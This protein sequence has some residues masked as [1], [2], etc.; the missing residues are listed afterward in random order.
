LKDQKDLN[1]LMKAL[2][3]LESELKRLATQFEKE[4][5]KKVTILGQE[6]PQMIDEDWENFREEKSKKKQY[7][8]PKVTE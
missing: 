5:G 1:T 8:R 2:P 4:H 7:V 3:K 6:I